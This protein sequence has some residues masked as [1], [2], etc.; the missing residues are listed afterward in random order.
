MDLIKKVNNDNFIFLYCLFVFYDIN[1]V[2]GKDVV[3]KFG[4]KEME[5]IDEVFCSKYVCYFD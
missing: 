5:V 2:Y 4:V 3:E 1:I